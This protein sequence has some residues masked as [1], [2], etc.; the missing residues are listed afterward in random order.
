MATMANGRVGP[1]STKGYMKD[2]K[3][4]LCAIFVQILQS[5]LFQEILGL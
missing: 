4:I 1:E 5:I 3:F 2:M